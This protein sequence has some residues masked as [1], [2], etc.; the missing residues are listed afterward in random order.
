MKGS[1]S[2]IGYRTM[3]QRL[4][5]HHN[6]VINKESFRNIF[7]IVD[8]VGV[9]NRS[10]YRLERRQYRRKGPNYIMIWHT[11]GYDKLKPFGFCIQ[12]CIDGYSRR[13]IWL[14]VGVT[15]N[16]P[17]VTAGYFLD[18]IHSV[19]RVPRILRADNGTENVHIAAFQRFFRREEVDAFAGEK[20]FMYGR[21]VSN[22]RI[23]AWW[24]Q[25]RKGGMDW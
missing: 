10:S 5:N 1:G 18:A 3:H 2:I 20:S 9:E 11:D 4:V 22:Q 13:I 17:D 23:D 21:S 25:L 14:E 15:N 12:D 16:D 19:G 6:L 8:P 7:R 24:D